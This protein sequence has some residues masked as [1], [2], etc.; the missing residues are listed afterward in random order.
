[1]QFLMFLRLTA[2]LI[3]FNY[4]KT[5]ICFGSFFM[6]LSS[7]ENTKH[8]IFLLQ[9]KDV[10]AC[11]LTQIILSPLNIFVKCSNISE[12]AKRILITA[13][14]CLKIFN[15]MMRKICKSANAYI[16]LIYFSELMLTI[17]SVFI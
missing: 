16:E 15:L 7:F 17:I 12:N 8:E 6:L 5:W 1:M 9:L 10:F 3:F 2:F 4:Q 11:T 13:N 14:S